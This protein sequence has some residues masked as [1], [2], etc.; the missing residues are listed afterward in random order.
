MLR[1]CVMTISFKFD[2]GDADSLGDAQWYARRYV[3]DHVM[4]D[5]SFNNTSTPINILELE[6]K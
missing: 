6:I 5:E 2:D 4:D 3:Q 1:Q